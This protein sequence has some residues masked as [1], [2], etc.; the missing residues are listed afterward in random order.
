MDYFDLFLS[1]TTTIFL[2]SLIP[3]FHAATSTISPNQSLADGGTI[4][5]PGGVFELGFFSPLRS[6]NR[7]IGIWY[8]NFSNSTIV[9]VA[10]RNSPVSNT[11]GSLAIGGDGNLV[12]LDG[13]QRVMWTSGVSLKTGDTKA[14]LLDTGNF[15]LRNSEVM[16][17]QSFDHATDTYLPGM[18]PGLDLRTNE[19]HQFTSWRSEDDPAPGKFTLGINPD[20]ST[21]I[22]IWD[23]GEPRWRSGRWNEQ[24]FIGVE[25]MV[26]EYIYGFRLNNFALENVMYFYYNPF[27]STPQRFVLSPAGFVKQ[28]EWQ[29]DSNSWQQIWAQP[30]TECELYN[31]CGNNA[32]CT[33]GR[34]AGDSP[35]CDCLKGYVRGSEG[36]VRRTPLQCERRAAAGEKD[37]FYRIGGLKLPDLSDWVAGSASL[38]QCEEICLRNCSCKAYSFVTG[39]GCL[40]WTRE[41]IDIHIFSDGGTDFYVRLAGSELAEKKVKVPL[42]LFVV[43]GLPA[44]SV[45][46]CICLLWMFRR[47]LR[48]LLKGPKRQQEVSVN[49]STGFS[50]VLL[51]EEEEGGDGKRIEST[52]FSFETVAAA[53]SNFSSSNFLGEG[54]FGPVYKGLLPGGQEIAVKRLSNSSGQGIEQFKNE[55]LLIAKLQHRNLV[56]LLGFC[57]QRDDKML[58]YEYMPNKSLDAFLFDQNKKRLL[59]WNTRYNIIEGIARGLL[60]LHRD[61]R[62]RVIHRDLKASNIL[63]DDSMN[64][65]ISDFGMAKIFGSD[66]NETTTKRVVGTY[67]YMSP[68][69]A[70]QGLF[71]VKSDVYSFGILVLEIVSGHRNSIY[72]HPDLYLNLIASAWKLWNEDNVMEFVDPSI[73]DS[74]LLIDV[75]RCVQL[76]LSCVQDRAND[77]PTMATAIVMLEG[78]TMAH[79]MPRQPTFAFERSTCETISTDQRF[80]SGNSLMITMVSGR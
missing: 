56:R 55:V 17:W 78:G 73:R 51:I 79:P 21:Q 50:G 65:R 13:Q 64:P 33:D 23:D 22:F 41:L 62:L 39:I 31:K 4:V 70:M 37:G 60:Y 63:L 3:S 10:N 32:T 59:D 25:G 75:S 34:N 36:C 12:V 14:A 15:V 16:V 77:R 40:V 52:V 47:K 6:T 20:R 46:G 72:Q 42:L 74:C 66:G 35:I 44:L 48:A 8:H 19:N 29:K 24:I 45:L 38:S 2:C 43:I 18:K 67:G 30:V 58:V 68:E 53:T 80:I 71:S 11:S 9:W 49:P 27:N 57:A 28:L 69:Y 61:S 76:G 54:G 26:G 1:L 7:Y 5:S